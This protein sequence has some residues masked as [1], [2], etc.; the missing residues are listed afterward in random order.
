M[1]KKLLLTCAAM[2]TLTACQKDTT[3]EV[4]QMVDVEL[5]VP[6]DLAVKEESRLQATISQGGSPVDDADVVD[7]EIWVANNREESVWL[8]AEQ[9][10]KGKYEVTYEFTE[11]GVY[12]I[13]THVTARDL[14]VMPV[15][16]VE[17]GEVTEE[18]RAAVQEDQGKADMSDTGHSHH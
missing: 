16:E 6:S 18:M 8:S 15:E 5:E 10:E 3:R 9:V 17:V 7:F 1:Y 2:I 4:Q 11:D 12:F 13:Q 14:H